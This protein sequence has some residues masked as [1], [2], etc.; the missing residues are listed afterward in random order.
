MI[1]IDDLKVIK[2]KK[3]KILYETIAAH[4]NYVFNLESLDELNN[5]IKRVLAYQNGYTEKD[6]LFTNLRKVHLEH[7]NLVIDWLTEYAKFKISYIKQPKIKRFDDLLLY[8]MSQSPYAFL[9]L[10]TDN[11]AQ[12][13]LEII[14]DIG[15]I[16]MLSF[17][18]K[19]DDA[20]KQHQKIHYPVQLI[21]DY[22]LDISFQNTYMKNESYAALWEM[23]H[24]KIQGYIKSVSLSL[25]QFKVDEI[26]FLEHFIDTRKAFLIEKRNYLINHLKKS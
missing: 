22:G 23:I 14:Y 8:A 13:H 2:D 10:I 20:L 18:L 24:F 5:Y 3:I 19:N 1:Q 11:L 4:L 26:L 6:K 9:M 21:E 7:P 16:D 25:N 17:I 12:R 15:K